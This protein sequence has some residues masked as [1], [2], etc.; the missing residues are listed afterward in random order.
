M[1]RVRLRLE[2]IEMFESDSGDILN[3]SD[4]RFQ[5]EARILYHGRCCLAAMKR[6]GKD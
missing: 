5:W 1:L 3:I 2:R 4:L 6:H